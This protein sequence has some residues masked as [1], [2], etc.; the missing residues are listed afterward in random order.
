MQTMS[1]S[2]EMC[3]WNIGVWGMFVGCKSVCVTIITTGNYIHKLLHFANN[4]VPHLFLFL[5]ISLL[6]NVNVKK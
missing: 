3:L 6:L 1:S 4:F 5:V 2:M